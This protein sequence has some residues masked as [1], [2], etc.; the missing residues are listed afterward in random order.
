MARKSRIYKVSSETI[1]AICDDFA[2]YN[3]DKRILAARHDVSYSTICG[4]LKDLGMTDRTHRTHAC[5][6][7]KAALK[8]AQQNGDK[9][10]PIK[11]IEVPIEKKATVAKRIGTIGMILAPHTDE[12]VAF[13][14]AQVQKT[15]IRAEVIK[16]VRAE[17]RQDME[18]VL[19]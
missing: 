10:V 9:V 14:F 6:E 2:Q 12:E 15:R 16:E 1:N 19:G 4:I 11:P 8:A 17:L 18:K 3:T 5:E 13:I 7:R